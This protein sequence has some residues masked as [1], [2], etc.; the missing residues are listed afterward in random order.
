MK[1]FSESTLQ[2]DTFAF[3]AVGSANSYSL[4]YTVIIQR[5][6]DS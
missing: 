3:R 6:K 1:H 5:K 4:D 2:D